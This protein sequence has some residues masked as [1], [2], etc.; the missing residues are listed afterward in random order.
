M[1]HVGG[2]GDGDGAGPDC[3]GGCQ[4][5]SAMMITVLVLLVLM[6]L[7]LVKMLTKASGAFGTYVIQ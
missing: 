1:R 2:A 6:T 5:D 7:V 4:H 3:W